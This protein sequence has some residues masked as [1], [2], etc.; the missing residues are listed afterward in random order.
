M[1]A[2]ALLLGGCVVRISY[3][4][5][6]PQEVPLGF[7]G[8]IDDQTI[9]LDL[10][11]LTLSAQIQ[12]FDWNGSTLPPP[13]G[14]WLEFDPSDGWITLDPLAITLSA[15][16]GEALQAVAFLGP[17][18][19]WFSPRALAAGCGPRRYHSGIAITNI[20]LSPESVLEPDA[21]LGIYPPSIGTVASGGKTC[22]MFWF[23]THTTPD[24]TYRLRIEDVVIDERVVSVPEIRFRQ[25]S[26][27]FWGSVP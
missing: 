13:L 17:S 25:G 14:I 19:S 1:P 22:F 11:E 4:A 8:E 7:S 16:D 23:D 2:L 27:R 6:V 3:E 18:R 21:D 15:D 20:G 24:H 9:T 5:S 12:A 26:L 10:P